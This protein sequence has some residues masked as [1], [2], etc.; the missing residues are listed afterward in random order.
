MPSCVPARVGGSGTRQLPVQLSPRGLP[1]LLS[2]V[3]LFLLLFFLVYLP[4]RVSPNMMLVF[5]ELYI[6]DRVVL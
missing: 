2:V 5:L 3:W 6:R 4:G 1:A